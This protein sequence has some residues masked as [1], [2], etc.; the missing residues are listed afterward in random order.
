[1]KLRTVSAIRPAPLRQNIA[2]VISDL[3]L[4]GRFRPGEEISDSGLAAEFQVS[5]GPVREALLI[6]AE[7]GLV[8]HTHNHGFQVPELNLGELQQIAQVRRPLE[9]LALA[10][11]RTRATA[12]DLKE[13]REL[14][15]KLLDDFRRGGTRA[16]ARAEL[17]FHSRVWEMSG[18][19][20]LTAALHRI[21][22][23]YFVYVSAFRLGRS[24]HSEELM[25]DMH[26]RYIDFVSGRSSETAE[27]CV[28][29]HLDLGAP[30]AETKLS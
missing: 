12:G 20:W 28:A 1:M 24:D 15:R 14:W 9:T 11:A 29:F 4:D 8:Q 16:C 23:P 19:P 25:T 21:C 6:L 13:M 3:L 30:G 10:L 18:N 7:K 27:S 22:V 26:Q 2:E 17:A 5:R